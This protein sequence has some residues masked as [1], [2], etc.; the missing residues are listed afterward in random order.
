MTATIT[1]QLDSAAAVRHTLR[2][3]AGLP[4]FVAGSCVAA[5][6][7]DKPYEYSDIDVFVPNPGVYFATVQRLLGQGY[8]F[9]NERFERMW[10]RHL[11][12]GFNHWHTNSMQLDDPATQLEVNVIY[13]RV[14]GHE[15]TKL[16][17]VLE[18]FDFGLLAMGFN[19][20]DGSFHDMRGYFFGGVDVRGPLP[21][22]PY[23]QHTVGQGYMSQHTMLRTPGRYARYAQTY[24]YDL[25]LVKPTLVE[26][27]AAYADYKLNRTKPDDIALGQIAQAIGSH[28]EQD[29][30]DELVQFE[31]DLPTADGLDAIMESLE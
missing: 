15:T 25:S 29:Q 13:K 2:C 31:K 14:D 7:Y 8:A 5:M 12:Y 19:A 17:Q 23:R 18:S 16:S 28:I 6:V 21:M 11:M 30:F 22:L 4:A 3:T 10:D 24:G 20:S 27:Y 1:H 9:K 26:G